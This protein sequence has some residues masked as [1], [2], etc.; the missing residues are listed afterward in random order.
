MNRA[1]SL[2]RL[3]V[4]G[5]DRSH[6]SCCPDVSCHSSIVKVQR[7]GRDSARRRPRIMGLYRRGVKPDDPRSTLRGPVAADLGRGGTAA[8]TRVVPGACQ[9]TAGRCPTGIRAGRIP[10]AG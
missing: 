2:R 6:I 1:V 7:R 3:Q 9:T 5:F 8:N 4:R 10:R